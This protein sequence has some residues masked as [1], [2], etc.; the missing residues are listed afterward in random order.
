[1]FR[2]SGEKLYLSSGIA[3]ATFRICF[4]MP[5]IW[6]STT[7]A[8]VGAASGEAQLAALRSQAIATTTKAATRTNARVHFIAGPT[9]VGAALAAARLVLAVMPLHRLEQLRRVV[10]HSVLEDELDVLD[11]GDASGRIALQDDEVRALADRNR[12][13]AACLTEVGGAVERRDPDRFDR[14][15]PGFDQQLDLALVT[16]ARDVSVEANGI[17]AGEEQPASRH[18]SAL[19]VHVAPQEAGVG[20][21]FRPVDRAAATVEVGVAQ[22]GRHRF[23]DPGRH[24]R[25]AF[26]RR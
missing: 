23:Q 7:D 4:S 14:R 13:D 10:T 22:R 9:L 18:E 12:A 26:R 2:L 15:K 3:S 20:F 25:P 21:L 11:V 16:V 8:T 1:M 24:R 6:R 5:V 17:R 19:Q